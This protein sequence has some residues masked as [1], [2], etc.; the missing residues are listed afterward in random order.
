MAIDVALL[1]DIGGKAVAAV[2]GGV[3]T[4]MFEKRTRLLAY[5][6][7]VGLFRLNPTPSSPLTAVH[8]HS[9]VIRNAGRLPAKNVRVP[10]RIPL[11]ASNVHV[12]VDPQ[13]A[14]TVTALPNGGDELRFDVLA[15]Q[16]MITIS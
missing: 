11:A 10:H 15:P 4:Y 12:S 3:V 5:Y 7:H 16:Q 2:V 8:T 14:Y 9:V 13:I 1:W 6:G